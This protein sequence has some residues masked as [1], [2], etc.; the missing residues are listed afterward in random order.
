MPPIF[1][2]EP[3]V[4][5]NAALIGEE[6]TFFSKKGPNYTSPIVAGEEGFEPSQ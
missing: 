6:P 2:E 1:G 4:R 5:T 3:F